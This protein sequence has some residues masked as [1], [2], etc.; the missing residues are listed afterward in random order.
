MSTAGA[1]WRLR[2]LPAFP[3]REAVPTR[4]YDLMLWR[5]GPHVSALVPLAFALLTAGPQSELALW[6]RALAVH[7][8][9]AVGQL[10][11]VWATD[12]DAHLL[13]TS[14]HD[15]T[16][17]DAWGTETDENARPYRRVRSAL[18]AALL[19][20]TG[21]RGGFIQYYSTSEGA[22]PVACRSPLV[23][24]T[25]PDAWRAV[26]RSAAASAVGLSG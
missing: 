9:V 20:L 15:I 22:L 21:V 3:S 13:A 26:F 25:G 24:T 19:A 5:D 16:P 12:A 4:N 18:E 14:A 23:N 7:E 1:R 6:G 8:R 10:A 2:P 17:E 11:G